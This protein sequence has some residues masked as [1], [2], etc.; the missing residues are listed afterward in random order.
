MFT[1]PCSVKHIDGVFVV[2]RNSKCSS[3][4]ESR[5]TRQNL[6]HTESILW[7][8]PT[9]HTTAMYLLEAST[10][11]RAAD[12]GNTP[13]HVWP[14]A[15]GR[16]P[17]L[18][19]TGRFKRPAFHLFQNTTTT[20]PQKRLPCRNLTGIQDFGG[21]TRAATPARLDEIVSPKGRGRMR[22]QRKTSGTPMHQHNGE[23]KY[24]DSQTFKQ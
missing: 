18:P 11:R 22:P 13:Y 4:Y 1:N 8:R 6:T 17:Q 9:A 2:G 3:A 20:F 7:A 16:C 12:R 23:Y 14:T 10:K 15:A 5:S 24:V 19:V 21:K